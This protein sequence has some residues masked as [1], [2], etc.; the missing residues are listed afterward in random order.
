[1]AEIV[2]FMPAHSKKLIA[3]ISFQCLYSCQLNENIAAN[4]ADGVQTVPL[5]FAVLPHADREMI[6]LQLRLPVS[7]CLHVPACLTH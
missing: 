3:K 4:Y 7:Q 1:M 6:A 2:V 5:V